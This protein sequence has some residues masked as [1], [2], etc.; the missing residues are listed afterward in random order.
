MTT[1]SA[2]IQNFTA[3][4]QRVS[5]QRQKQ[6]PTV[7]DASTQTMPDTTGIISDAIRFAQRS[8]D[9]Q[10]DGCD[11]SCE[12]TTTGT[13]ATGTTCQQQAAA[14]QSAPIPTQSEED[15]NLDPGLLFPNPTFSLGLTQEERAAL[16]KSGKTDAPDLK[17]VTE[18]PVATTFDEP[19]NGFRRGKRQKVPTKLFMGEYECDK[20]SLNRARKSV[21]NAIYKGGDLDYAAKFALLLDKMQTPL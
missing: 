10:A 5:G 21:T 15:M 17:S 6:Q 20:T 12:N 2:E 1:L 9:S 14:E 19:E 16:G 4:G 8:T 11:T 13:A 7:V 18:E 3:N